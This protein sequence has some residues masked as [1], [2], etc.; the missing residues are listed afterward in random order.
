MSSARSARLNQID[1]GQSIRYRI[2]MGRATKLPGS[3]HTSE[4]WRIHEITADFRLEDVWA[5]PTPGGPNDFDRLAEIIASTDP[6]RESTFVV[7]TL[8]A[9]RRKLG[10]LFGWDDVD[11]GGAS[12]IPTL[13]DRLP[14]DLRKAPAPRSFV[15]LPFSVLYTTH[16]EFA[17][18]LANQTMHGVLHVGWVPDGAGAYRGQLA[19]LV[20]PNG[21]LGTIYM[22]AI[23]PF[24]HLFVYPALTRMLKKRWSRYGV[25]AEPLRR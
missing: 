9:V 23:R 2:V 15:G 7:R 24:R 10:D 16:N 19:V 4:P 8:F 25:E 1:T 22:A 13:R 5:L 21:L 11:G 6:S 17:A 20:K 12:G 14:L 18:E 3:A